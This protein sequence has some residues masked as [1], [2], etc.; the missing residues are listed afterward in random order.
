MTVLDKIKRQVTEESLGASVATAQAAVLAQIS[1]NPTLTKH[2]M[3]ESG[4]N[5]ATRL[6][7]V[8]LPHA[9]MPGFFSPEESAAI[10]DF[11]KSCDNVAPTAFDDV[12]RRSSTLSTVRSIGCLPGGRWKL[13]Y[14]VPSGQDALDKAGSTKM[15]VVTRDLNRSI[16]EYRDAFL[17]SRSLA[18]KGRDAL[19]LPEVHEQYKSAQLKVA[20]AEEHVVKDS[21][22]YLTARNDLADLGYDVSA[23]DENAEM[24]SLLVLAVRR[25]E[26]DPAREQQ[27][28]IKGKAP[29][30]SSSSLSMG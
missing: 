25:Y 7:G 3:S 29:K 11:V 14:S 8:A 23:Y 19:N 2:Y 15:V 5:A 22:L 21:E 27:F 4:R 24:N 16:Q 13:D 6:S 9:R 12:K 28:S 18:A 30:A 20:R 26:L 1:K 10:M 17:E